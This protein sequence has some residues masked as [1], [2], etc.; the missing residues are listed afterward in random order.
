MNK[1]SQKSPPGLLGTIKW[2]LPASV[3]VFFVAVPLCLGIALASGAPLISGLISGIVGGIVV[4]ALSGSP[5]GV[6]GP[7]AGLAVIVL[8][9]IQELGAFDIFLVSVV[10]AGMIQVVLGYARAGIIAYYFPSSVITGMLSGIGIVIFLKQIPHALGYD[11]DPE[12]DFAFSQLDGESTISALGE[13][14]NRIGLGAV[15]ITAI[16]LAILIVWQTAWVKRRPILSLVPGPLL[17]VITGVILVTV[18]DSME[19]LAVSPDHLVSIPAF[20]GLDS[21]VTLP[22]FSAL[23]IGAVYKTAVVLAV[24]ASLETLLCAEA[25]DNLDPLKRITP[26]NRELKAQGVGN[27]VAGFI[28]GLPVTQVIVRSSANIQAGGRSKIS[29]IGHGLLLLLGVVALTSLLNRIPLATLAAIL[30]IVGY[31]LAKPSLFKKMFGE[32]PAQW[33]PF[34]I[35]VAGIV[36]IDLLIGLGLGLG[37]AVISLLFE[38]FQIPFSMHDGPERIR[39][40]LAQHVTFLNKASIRHA[41]STVPAGAV[42]EI[43]ARESAFVHND[44]VEIIHDFV[45][46]S[47]ARDIEVS[48][49]GLEHHQKGHPSSGMNMSAE[50]LS[51]QTT[52]GV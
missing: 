36:F 10:L 45:I 52:T 27:I 46:A 48:L 51:Q 13:A 35:T 31:K 24:V 44:I 50:P 12:G 39:F 40:K 6:S 34:L 15:I 49:L 19:A 3:V 14:L 41:L 4:G 30:L 33:I 18:F 32:G 29:A 28:G 8:T 9:A 43:D 21:L 17:A 26:T 11:K 5:L 23:G 20:T 16:S 7:A 1:P 25:T 47:E 38:N 22:D 2:D 37:A 42:V